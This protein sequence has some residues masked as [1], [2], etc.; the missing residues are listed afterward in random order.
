MTRDAEFISTEDV[1]WESALQLIPHDIYHTPEYVTIAAATADPPQKAA[2][3]YWRE[4]DACALV[5]LLFSEF[6]PS[7]ARV[8]PERRGTF[9]GDGCSPYGYGGPITNRP[10]QCEPQ[11]L[12]ALR[13]AAKAA[14]ILTLFLRGHPLLGSAF[15]AF[16]G[17]DSSCIGTTYAIDLLKDQG[18]TEIGRALIRSYRSSH[19]KRVKAILSDSSIQFILDDWRQVSQFSRLYRKNME[20][21]SASTSYFF[22][23]HYFSELRRRL[24]GRVSL[25]S[26]INGEQYVGGALLFGCSNLLQCHLTA[27]HEEWR[28]KGLPKALIHRAAEWGAHN[29][30]RAFHLGGGLGGSNDSL[31]YFKRGFNPVPYD[32]RVYRMIIDRSFYRAVISD[33]AA[34]A[35]TYFPVYRAPEVLERTTRESTEMM[36]AAAGG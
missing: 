19:G 5:P 31:A 10:G 26:A 12:F 32:Y 25:L 30:Y 3:F 8:L 15:C 29:G 1:R 11:V 9:W 18:N 36:D 35:T 2:A 22:D 20:R 17:D 23:D 27:C 33:T 16:E 13:K 34:A 28:D 21:L 4:G 24:N 6:P 14:G 7:L